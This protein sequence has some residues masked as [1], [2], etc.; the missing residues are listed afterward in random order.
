MRDQ[1]NR[2]L[3][4]NPAAGGGR[5]AREWPRIEHRLRDR[6]LTSPV[7]ETNAPNHA[8]DLAQRALEDGVETVVSVGGDGTMCEVIA[9]MVRVGRGTLG[10]LPLGTG[11][12]AA[13][14]LGIPVELDAATDILVAGETRSVDL[15]RIG[16]R[17]ALNAIGIGLLGDINTRAVRLKRVRGIA[18]YL[19]AALASLCTFRSP[20]V[21]LSSAEIDL[22][23]EMTVLAVHGGPTTGGGF[24][25][26]PGADPTDGL[27][28][29]CF[30]GRLPLLSRPRRLVAALRGTLG[31]LPR[32]QT[33]RLPAFTLQFESPIPC[34]LDG[35][36]W[37]LDPPRIDVEVLP[38]A[39]KVLTP[40]RE[41]S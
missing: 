4:V 13:G 5:L 23:E 41:T 3:I 8:T 17:V 38:R 35:N 16:D 31:S 20:K 36:V 22:E 18:A 9:G 14:T 21:R 6:G 12:D 28:D 19:A 7:V 25:L 32:S 33:F 10:I 2:L 26:A 37:Q 40:T 29:I 1:D 11:N 30:V 27:M 24:K 39:I 34:H 15:I